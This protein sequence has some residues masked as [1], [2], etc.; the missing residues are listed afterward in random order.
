VYVYVYMCVVCEKS[1]HS[2]VPYTCMCV[3]T[4]VALIDK[5]ASL[6]PRIHDIWEYVYACV[7]VRMR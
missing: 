6:K 5:I 1:F 2:F 4:G 7:C 3:C